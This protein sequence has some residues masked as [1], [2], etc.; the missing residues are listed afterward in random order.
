[1]SVVCLCAAAAALT[2]CLLAAP[3]YQLVAKTPLK[4]LY[5]FEVHWLHGLDQATTNLL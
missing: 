4:A 2:M 5:F 3:N 1:M